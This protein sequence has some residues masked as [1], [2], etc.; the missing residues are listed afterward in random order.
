M[1]M[2]TDAG[3]WLAENDGKPAR[4][5]HWKEP[6]RQ[7]KDPITAHLF[8]AAMH[9]QSPREFVEANRHIKT[10]EC[11]F[12]PGAKRGA[13]SRLT[14]LGKS[15]SAARYMALLTFGTPRHHDAVTRH[16]CGNGHLSCINP[17]HLEWGSAQDNRRD[18][19]KHR[20]L[21]TAQD[22]IHAV[23]GPR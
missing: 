18:A 10:A 19:G 14:Y 20:G 4:V 13:P 21:E 22:K 1:P 2:K 7:G 6:R 9:K 5:A 23:A 17:A 8:N 16:L 11:V 3:K 15:I 12:V